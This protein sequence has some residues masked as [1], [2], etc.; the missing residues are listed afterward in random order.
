MGPYDE[1][2]EA[3]TDAADH[4]GLTPKEYLQRSRYGVSYTDTSFDGVDL[5]DLYERYELGTLDD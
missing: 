1:Y 5:D 4:Y 2:D 3:L